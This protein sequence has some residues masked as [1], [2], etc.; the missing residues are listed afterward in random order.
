MYQM[1][2]DFYKQNILNYLFNG[3]VSNNTINDK[4]MQKKCLNSKPNLKIL[5]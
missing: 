4:Y 1:Y 3:I 2:L 5:L